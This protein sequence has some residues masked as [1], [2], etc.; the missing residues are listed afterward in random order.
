MAR[1]DRKI[2]YACSSPGGGYEPA[3]SPPKAATDPGRY[4]CNPN[5]AQVTCEHCR[6]WLQETA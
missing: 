6:R 1:P 3:C 2:H 5:P 4:T